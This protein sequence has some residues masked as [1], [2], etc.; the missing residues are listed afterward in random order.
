MPAGKLVLVDLAGSE[1]LK[2][3]GNSEKE[4]LRETGHINRSLFTLG[5][6]SC[7]STCSRL[8]AGG[9]LQL[10]GG[11]WAP[12][13]GWGAAGEGGGERNQEAGRSWLVP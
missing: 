4:A 1:R 12:P 3:T 13:A 11:R 8:E 10:P 5:Q 2:D 7:G 6:V 9:H